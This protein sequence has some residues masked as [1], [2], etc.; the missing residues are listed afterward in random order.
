MSTAENSGDSGAAPE[1]IEKEIARHRAELG[2]TIDELSGRLDVTRQAKRQ[3]A[4]VRGMVADGLDLAAAN[5]RLV[6][7]WAR[8]RTA[9]QWAVAM[10]PVLAVAAG[11]ILVRARARRKA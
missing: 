6:V 3:A 9:K 11:I 5:A 2:A 1:Q 4:Q 8:T 10:G 7:A